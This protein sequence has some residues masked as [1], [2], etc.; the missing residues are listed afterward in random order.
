MQTRLKHVKA[1]DG[2]SSGGQRAYGIGDS[3]PDEDGTFKPV[4]LPFLLKCC[5]PVAVFLSTTQSAV[6]LGL[7]FCAELWRNIVHKG[8][9]K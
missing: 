1:E 6:T 8:C 2:A 5:D 7:M 4:K 3:Q 9:L